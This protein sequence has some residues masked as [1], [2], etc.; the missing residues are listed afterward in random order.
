MSNQRF[1]MKRR[2]ALR[3]LGIGAGAGLLPSVTD[4]AIAA[5]A[6]QPTRSPAAD[7]IPS[8][9]IVRTLLEDVP[10]A[11]LATVLFHEH[12]S[13]NLRP[14]QPRPAGAPPPPTQNVDMILELVKRAGR[15]GV[16]CIVDGGHPDMGRDLAALKRMAAE[17]DVHIVA[18]GGYYMERTYPPEVASKSEQEVASD[19]EEEARASRYGAFGEIGQMPNLAEMTANERKVFAAVGRAHVRT[20]I[21]IFTHNAYGTGPNV[22]PDAGLRQ[23]DVLESVGVNPRHVAIGHS[24]CLDD[25]KADI[26]RQ[27]AKRG[28]FVGFDRVTT[29]QQIMPDATKVQ[30]VLAILEAGLADQLLLSA[31][32]T[33][34]R[35]LEDGPGYARTVTVFLPLLRQ[36][37]VKDEVL[38]NIMT[39][40]ARRFLA[41]VPRNG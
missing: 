12:L 4:A 41:F 23:L 36:A 33:G 13:I 25:L 28:A 2:E 39:N 9:A 32:F 21:P 15:E 10:P 7:G 26:F 38:Q 11:S 30:M 34:Q 18:S 6:K 14:A 29:V 24:C 19:L 1:G 37:G 3:L 40:N 5:L 8:G 35:T 16:S 22:R 27:I 20:G 17:T 31:D